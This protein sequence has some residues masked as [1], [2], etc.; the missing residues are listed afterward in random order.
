MTASRKTRCS[1]VDM[2]PHPANNSNNANKITT[3]ILFI[4][5]PLLPKEST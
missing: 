3:I 1:V 4:A 2:F 5:I